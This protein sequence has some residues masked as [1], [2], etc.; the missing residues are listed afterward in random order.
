MADIIGWSDFLF[1]FFL[2]GVCMLVLINPW[3]KTYGNVCFLSSLYVYVSTRWKRNSKVIFSEL[4]EA[5]SS[6]SS[7]S[8]ATA[9]G[10]VYS[11]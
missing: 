8:L 1:F 4:C 11:F 6:I 2:S 10:R 7:G 3:I 5:T 9:R